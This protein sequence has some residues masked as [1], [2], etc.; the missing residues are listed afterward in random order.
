[1]LGHNTKARGADRQMR[2]GTREMDVLFCS[3]MQ[4]GVIGNM[5]THCKSGCCPRVNLRTCCFISAQI[6]KGAI[7]L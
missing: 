3:V 2:G 5:L 4:H 6:A 1:M 7:N